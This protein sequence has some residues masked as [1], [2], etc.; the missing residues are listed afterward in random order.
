MTDGILRLY[1]GSMS[2]GLAVVGGVGIS[3][4][5]CDCVFIFA[6]RWPLALIDGGGAELY[7]GGI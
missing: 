5:S 7:I 6:I 2:T 4:Y 3:T 1:I